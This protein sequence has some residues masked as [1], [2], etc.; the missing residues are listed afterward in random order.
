MLWV[1]SVLRGKRRDRFLPAPPRREALRAGLG[2]LSPADGYD[3]LTLDDPWP[4]VAEL[5]RIAK[6]LPGKVS[7]AQ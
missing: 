6:K 4:G 1:A 3:I 2:W 5:A 7:N